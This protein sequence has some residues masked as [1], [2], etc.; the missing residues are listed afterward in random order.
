MESGT[1]SSIGGSGLSLPH[2]MDLAERYGVAFRRAGWVGEDLRW[3]RKNFVFW[4]IAGTP[5]G[6]RIVRY[7]DLTVDDFT[8]RDYTTL[9]SGCETAEP[10]CDCDSPNFGSAAAAALVSVNAETNEWNPNAAFGISCNQAAVS[11]CEC[12]TFEVGFGPPEIG[13]VEA[14]LYSLSGGSPLARP[15]LCLP[16]G[17]NWAERIEF[18]WRPP[19]PAP[20][21]KWVGLLIRDREVLRI[22]VIGEDV[23]PLAEGLYYGG[24]DSGRV[25]GPDFDISSEEIAGEEITLTIQIINLAT[26]VTA[27]AS[28]TFTLA[29]LCAGSGSGSV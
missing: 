2:A 21:G 13:E 22:K 8:A 14:D 7:D 18:T 4:E 27:R 17:V 5:S 29:P 26:G 20:P 11:E 12:G 25:D 6:W 16:P 24:A 3:I 15:L 19:D 28:D 9:P 1:S 10:G 23:D